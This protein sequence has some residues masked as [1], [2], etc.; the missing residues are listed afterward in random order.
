MCIRDRSQIFTPGFSSKIN[1]ATG[2]VNRG[3]G[4]AIVRELAE[5]RLKGSVTVA[6]RDG[7]TVFTVRIPKTQLEETAHASVS[8]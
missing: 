3:L 4:L 5:D 2:E 6:C 7:G 1:Y 8:D